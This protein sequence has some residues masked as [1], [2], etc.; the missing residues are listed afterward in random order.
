MH[1]LTAM[2]IISVLPYTRL[3]WRTPWVESNKISQAH[4][5]PLKVAGSLPFHNNRHNRNTRYFPQA[6]LHKQR[7]QSRYTGG[8]IFFVSRSKRRHMLRVL[9]AAFGPTRK[10]L[11]GSRILP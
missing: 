10:E 2:G 1:E 5:E 11:E 4:Y 3:K 7:K 9:R 8:P 6:V